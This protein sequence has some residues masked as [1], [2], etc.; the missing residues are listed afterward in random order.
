VT[1]V[2]DGFEGALAIVAASGPQIMRALHP[3]SKI[4]V[5]VNGTELSRRA[6]EMAFVIARSNDAH[7]TA[8]YVT[9][10]TRSSRRG[11]L[12][13]G[14]A[15]R[16]NEEA[17]LKEVTELAD[18]YG[19]NVQT[20]MRVDAAADDAVIKEALRGKFDLIILGVTRRPGETLTFGGMADTLLA[21][22]KLSILFVAG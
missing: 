11:R 12:Q 6:V 16:S 10:R 4:L 7:V 3:K 14:S 20:A 9:G 17:V 15:T 18:R 2:A 22:S 19:V 5:P 8:L 13:L 1:H 21:N